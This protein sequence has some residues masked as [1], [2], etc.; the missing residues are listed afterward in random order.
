MGRC[1]L[2]PQVDLD[3]LHPSPVGAGLGLESGN[4]QALAGCE[5]L[6]EEARFYGGGIN[7]AKTIREPETCIT[8]MMVFLARS[9]GL[10]DS[11]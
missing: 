1:G 2:Q 6:W 8:A 7:L 11:R 4:P 5:R 10:T 9:F 3:H